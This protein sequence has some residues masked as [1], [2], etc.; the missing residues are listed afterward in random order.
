MQAWP[1]NNRSTSYDSN[2][3]VD[4]VPQGKATMGAAACEAMHIMAMEAH[5]KTLR[6]IEDM[7]EVHKQQH[8][9]FNDRMDTTVELQEVQG[10]TLEQLIESMQGLAAIPVLAQRLD[11]LIVKLDTGMMGPG[12]QVPQTQVA[13]VQPEGRWSGADD[14]PDLSDIQTR[15]VSFNEH[16]A[17]SRKPSHHHH[18]HHA[19]HHHHHHRNHGNGDE[20]DDVLGFSS[21]A[22]MAQNV[23]DMRDDG[24]GP[25]KATTQG[26]PLRKD[27]E[28]GRASGKRMNNTDRKEAVLSEMNM[29]PLE[30]GEKEEQVGPVERDPI[31]RLGSAPWFKLLCT[32]IVISSVVIVALEANLTADYAM[33]V[34][35][36][37]AG[38]APAPEYVNLEMFV[39]LEYIMVI[40][41][42]FELTVNVRT[43]GGFFSGDGWGWNWFDISILAATIMQMAMST[44]D[45]KAL[46]VV[47]LNR[48]MKFV[49]L[50]RL[51]KVLKTLRL[52]RLLHGVRKMILSMVGSLTSLFWAIF[53]MF[54]IMFLVS[55]LL[56]QG[57]EVHYDSKV[58]ELIVEDPNGLGS[59]AA[60]GLGNWTGQPPFNEILPMFS[61]D[62]E[63]DHQTEQVY[64]LYGSVQKT[65][66]TLFSTISGGS[67]WPIVADP[68]HRISWGFTALWMIFICVMVFGVL[69]ILT[70]IFV[71]AAMQAAQSD[72]TTIIM[73]EKEERENATMVLKSSFDKI[74]VDKSGVLTRDEFV[75]LL[76]DEE[77]SAMLVH[78]GLDPK[79]AGALFTLLDEDR[80]GS[81]SFPEFL[82]GCLGLKGAAKK[83]DI[84]TVMYQ[85][86]RLTKTM[87]SLM[88]MIDEMWEDMD[89]RFEEINPGQLSPRSPG[90]SR[91][92]RI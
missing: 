36:C 85:N 30:V 47:R 73:K 31:K 16:S 51:G 18:H 42:I 33:N 34:D 72:R 12:P 21:L 66:L 59:C 84:I 22:Q 10:K 15:G 4:G 25:N 56:V 79:E 43:T 8:Y 17:G 69:N 89:E 2:G 9:T 7:R 83:I 38:R 82:S 11:E 37:K 57:V 61:V 52:V 49:R 67:E 76:Q 14:L 50:M 53:L 80:S 27:A 26:V 5:I 71:D 32:L 3:L 20:Y 48:L 19:S 78:I 65:M 23:S 81:V 91:M 35:L 46:R 44:V 62:P 74:D 40:W 6:A 64:K 58:D 29:N 77:V 90:G 13:V 39:T 60:G 75:D 70:G 86:R 68:V 1:R 41:M 87:V 54:F 45:L 55:V 63:A 28:L 92:A 88:D 24:D